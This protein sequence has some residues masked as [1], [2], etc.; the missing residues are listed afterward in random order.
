VPVACATEKAAMASPASS[1]AVAAPTPTGFPDSIVGT[2]QTPAGERVTI[3]FATGVRHASEAAPA[4]SS[5][6]C[7]ACKAP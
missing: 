6:T 3:Q 4:S 7:V 5:A 1:M 2:V